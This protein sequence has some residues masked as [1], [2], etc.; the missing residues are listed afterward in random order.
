M[1]R[2][3]LRVVNRAFAAASA[4]V[5]VFVLAPAIASAAVENTFL[6][7]FSSANKPTFT[8][9][10]GMVVDPATGDLLVLDSSAA[11]ISRWKP[12][13]T[14]SNFS[15]LG[16]NVIDGKGGADLTPQNG[17]TIPTSA[18]E[19][20]IAIDNSGGAT[21]GN[22]YITHGKTMITIFSSTGAYLGQLT[23]FA[24]SC[25]VAV[26]PAGRVYVG[27]FQGG[28]IV[29][30][31]PSG[32]APV[33]ADKTATLP[34]AQT[35][36]VSAGA[37]PTNG[38]LFAT[39]FGGTVSKVDSSTGT[40][41]Y[42]V[43][44]G[45]N[46]TSTVDPLTGLV[47][48]AKA[49][50]VQKYDASSAVSPTFLT[51]AK[52]G[53]T[54]EGVAADG[55]RS[56]IYLSRSVVTNADVFGPH[57]YSLA[58]NSTGGTGTGTVKCQVGAGPEEACKATY[59]EGTALT[60]VPTAAAGN[61]FAGFSG[62]TGAASACAG[63]S[64]CSFTANNDATV[65]APF[66]LDPGQKKITISVVSQ[67]QVKCNGAACAPNYAEGSTIALEAVPSPNYTFSGWSAFS[68]SGAV[69][70]PCTGTVSPCEV[71]LDDNVTGTATFAP[72]LHTLNLS[73]V[74]GGA[75]QCK[76][77]A[78]SYGACAATY[79]Q[80]DVVKIKAVPAPNNYFKNWS[81]VTGSGSVPTPC[82]ANT[83]ECEV[84]LDADV[85]GIGNFAPIP[86]GAEVAHVHN[87]SFSV[88][89]EP[90]SLAV[91][92]LT[93]S[94]YVLT[95]N[96][97]NAQ[98]GRLYKYDSQGAPSN[99]SALG[100]NNFLVGCTQ[101]CRQI[102]VDNSGGIN[103]GVIYV[104][105]NVSPNFG[106]GAGVRVYVP[107]GRPSSAIANS[108][109]STDFIDVPYCGVAVD[110]SGI[111]YN[112]H[113]GEDSTNFP[114]NYANT[115]KPGQILPDPFPA[116][117]WAVGARIGN[118]ANPNPCRV[119]VDSKGHMYVS[120]DSAS[121]TNQFLERSVLRYSVD[122][123][124]NSQPA[125]KLIDSASTGLAVDLSGDDLYSNRKTSIARFNLNGEL[126][127]IFGSGKLADS[128]GIAV[129][130]SN[131]FV[132]AA[133]RLAK[134]IQ[135]FST[136]VTPAVSD[137]SSTTTSPTSADLGGSVDGS[138]VGSVNSCEFEYG[139]TTAYGT[140]KPCAESMP[141]TGKEDV[142]A[143][144]TGLSMETTYH[145]RLVVTN[146]YGTTRSPDREFTTH[147]VKGVSTDPPSDVTQTSATLNGSFTGEGADVTYHFEWG[148]TA[149]Y[150]NT[151]PAKLVTAP[152]GT[153]SASAP[154]TG[155]SV[156]L[157]ESQPY[158]YRLVATNASGTTL[159][160][161]RT[162]FSAPPDPPKVKDL[163]TGEVT[164]TT[165]E[166][167]A[168]INPGSGPTVYWV[169]FGHDGSYGTATP[170]SAS[171]GA[172]DTDH[173]VTS[174]L[175]GLTPGTTYH[176]RV[177]ATNFGGTFT[178]ADQSFNTPNTP[179]ITSVS[180][181]EVGESGATLSASINP[182]FSTTTYRF[183]YGLTRSYGS[184]TPESVVP[185]AGN[186]DQQVSAAIA[187]LKSGVV[188]HY[189]AVASNAQGTVES[190]DQ[191]LTTTT[192]PVL[193][194]TAQTRPAAVKCKKGFVKKHGKCKKK[195]KPRKK[196][197][198]K[199]SRGE[200]R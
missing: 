200:S 48:V 84:K 133:N 120:P 52:A 184:A 168:S 156:Y 57:L 115:Y 191:I 173:G 65:N 81:A 170:T 91:D 22:I 189:R 151:T 126:L 108:S 99:F 192:P 158:H 11:T 172:D 75:F 174:E 101:E 63:T 53:S 171:V 60:L 131:G 4:V 97:V 26:D 111:L 17:I 66:T 62:G 40:V 195:K 183:E 7:T 21:N 12:D 68:G 74:G 148:P 49:T 130:G 27:D 127:E 105:T 165:A 61:Q 152:V 153:K 180:S 135:V 82:A 33:N 58:V 6:E 70:T 145:W 113:A 194:Q 155:L 142:S 69:A 87:S 92:E 46:T 93:G 71:K 35:C 116:Q 80:E 88:P 186:T 144:L 42:V 64:P 187:G 137:L 23:G 166:L 185:A 143:S 39:K 188:Y 1:R 89:D 198:P 10:K 179:A 59:P 163:L 146:A 161:D 19:G 79:V 175:E 196:R 139:T 13:G 107:S 169:E 36:T 162:F 178:S 193:R 110:D 134:V 85:T 86:A 38:F 72:I 28:G 29:K 121:A 122:P 24:E 147:N 150:G 37:G 102:A 41:Q 83:P 128:G 96:P 56:R 112:V 51:F 8:A 3:S 119:A 197:K 43:S 159:G 118:I 138:S 94:V 117:V 129:N 31:V 73:A 124:T 18:S 100:S 140:T 90:I 14:P 95:T 157:P 54:V 103:Q 67:G 109:D 141:F 45:S 76:V 167:S 77:G 34:V 160:P 181:S 55:S 123:F 149:S 16:T 78:G 104:G 50:E 132:Y 5:L 44:A 47:Y 164:P 125:G 15:A 2:S 190:A 114:K 9:D 20:Q 98:A 106:T 182:G 177:V 154:V 25:G 30:F 176:Y 32:S 136:V 199:T